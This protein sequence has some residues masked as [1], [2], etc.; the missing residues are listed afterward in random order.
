MNGE[1]LKYKIFNLDAPVA[2]E[3]LE[4]SSGAVVNHGRDR[5]VCISCHVAHASPYDSMLR[6]DYDA[7]LTE[8]KSGCMICHSEK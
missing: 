8:Q 3:T 5:V 1:Y 2:R 4:M 7:L 6:W